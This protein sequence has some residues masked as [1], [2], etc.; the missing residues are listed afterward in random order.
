MIIK[1]LTNSQSSSFFMKI[2]AKKPNVKKLIVYYKFYYEL[3]K[4][5]LEKNYFKLKN[6]V[7]F[8]YRIYLRRLARPNNC[9][10]ILHHRMRDKVF[11]ICEPS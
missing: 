7:I 10:Y 3:C 9:E 8:Y 6:P 11:T 4:A 2:G 5:C 1:H